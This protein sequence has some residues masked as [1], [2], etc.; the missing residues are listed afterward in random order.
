MIRFL[1]VLFGFAAVLTFAPHASA[2]DTAV[3]VDSAAGVSSID[4]E[5]ALVATPT[6]VA[7]GLP[8]APPPPR[9][10]RAYW[11]VFIA[12]ALAWTLL[13]GYAIMLGR[14]F[15]ALEREVRRIE[16]GTR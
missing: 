12:F 5:P 10:L 3:V 1:V 13:F 14:R 11:H 8:Q 15:G 7:T 6:G 2:Q 4:A 9:T 16:G